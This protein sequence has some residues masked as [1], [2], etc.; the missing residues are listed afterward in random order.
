MKFRLLLWFYLCECAR[1][2]SYQQ[3]HTHTQVQAVRVLLLFEVMYLYIPRRETILILR[4]GSVHLQVEDLR[5]FVKIKM[6]YSSM[7]SSLSSA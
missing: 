6:V 1:K 3:T 7:D 5:L 2:L 4:S